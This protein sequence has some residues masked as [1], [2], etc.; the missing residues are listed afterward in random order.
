MIQCN[1][2]NKLK[3]YAKIIAVFHLIVGIVCMLTVVGM[4]VGILVIFYGMLLAGLIS[5]SGEIEANTRSTKEL[6]EYSANQ[7]KEQCKLQNKLAAETLDVLKSID[8]NQAA[9]GNY[10]SEQICAINTKLGAP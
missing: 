9:V 7:Y 1:N 5:C 10:V 3:F 2:P 8:R 4:L 6:L